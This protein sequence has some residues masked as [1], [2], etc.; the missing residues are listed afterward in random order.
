MICPCRRGF[1]LI[2]TIVALGIMVLIASMA[3]STMAG[4]A[5]VREYLVHE[6][7]LSRA[8]QTSIDRISRELSLAYLTQHNT[9]VNT[10]RTV[11]VGRDDGDADTLWFAS[12]A[13]RR[14]YRG[15]RESDAAEI[16]LF[17]EKDPE[18]AGQLALLHRES[19]RVDHEPARGGPVLPLATGVSRFDLRYLESKTGEWME[20]WDSTGVDQMG[21][22]PRAVQIVLTLLGPDPDDEGEFIERTWVRTVMIESATP[23]TRSLLAGD[24]SGGAGSLQNMGKGF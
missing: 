19:P 18:V 11:F 5:Q 12:R 13:H 3:W 1:T 23:L 15:A 17:T 22:L 14:A 20:D 8:G 2:E 4:T 16:T 24:G 7:D 10:Y 21:R 6:D 9:A